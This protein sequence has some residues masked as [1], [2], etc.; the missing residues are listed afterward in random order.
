MSLDI[1]NV[2]DWLR[3]F[4][5]DVYA[6]KSDIPE[7]AILDDN[8]TENSGNAVKSSGIY[9]ALSGKSNNGHTHI[10]S[11]ITDF[12]ILDGTVT[13][14]S[15]NGVKSS[16]IYTAL[17]EKADKLLLENPIID[18]ACEL[19]Q[20]IE[21]VNNDYYEN[22]DWD[23]SN[24]H[25]IDDPNLMNDILLSDN[26]ESPIYDVVVDYYGV[27]P[28]SI[29]SQPRPVLVVLT[30]SWCIPDNSEY[31]FHVSYVDNDYHV[32]YLGKD[33]TLL[34]MA[35]S[36]HTHG[37]I[38]NDGKVGSTENKPLITTTSGK[39]TT[40]S[41]GTSAN[42]FCQGN[43]SR[44]S[45]AR[46]PTSHTHTTSEITDILDKMYPVGSI[47]MSVNPNP[48]PIGTWKQLKNAFLYASDSLVTQTAETATN[49][50]AS[51]TLTIAEMPSH[52]HAHSNG[53][54]SFLTFYG[55]GSDTTNG[56]AG[57]NLWNGSKKKVT[58]ISNTGGGGSHN[59]MPPYMVVNMW[60]RTA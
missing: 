34:S 3:D 21:V 35:P 11:E 14:D 4:L 50:E 52:G 48:P 22:G 53:G 24:Y 33:I 41:F 15:N 60:K 1:S 13:S 31:Y 54:G 28:A 16:G 46:T 20:V 6:L 12:P 59:N 40:G 32:K 42:T 27:L 37:N 19:Y 44:L 36:S 49:G 45:N 2:V 30:D 39:I 38:T 8:V 57:G 55:N 9:S 43:D 47:Y 58:T 10:K 25:S 7:G 56:F 23:F 26:L 29:F 51:H 17:E 18:Y 5:D